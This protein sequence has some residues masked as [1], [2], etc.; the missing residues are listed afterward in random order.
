M[1]VCPIVCW[2]APG[3]EWRSGRA[4]G[5]A[6]SSPGSARTHSPA[7]EAAAGGEHCRT[8]V[9]C[10]GSTSQIPPTL[11][12]TSTPAQI[13]SAEG[14]KVRDV[15][16]LYVLDWAFHWPVW[17]WVGLRCSLRS[18]PGEGTWWGTGWRCASAEW[19]E[20]SAPS[21]AAW[22]QPALLT[23]T[24]SSPQNTGWWLAGGKTMKDERKDY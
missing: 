10:A 21:A 1:Y 20:A 19:G 18:Q 15:G 6:L 12:D 7:V 11:S 16:T 9:W 24:R 13:L 17:G 2:D 3:E 22:P 8:G 14:Y 23:C 4:A 5:E